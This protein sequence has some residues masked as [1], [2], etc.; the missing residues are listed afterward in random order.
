LAEVLTSA[1]SGVEVLDLTDEVGLTGK[2][3]TC[4][5]ADVILIEKPGG[6]KARRTEPFKDDVP[7]TENSR[8][9]LNFNTNKRGIMSDIDMI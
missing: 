1:L 2:L 6:S 9:F 5:G 8:Y 4:L 3:I 7:G